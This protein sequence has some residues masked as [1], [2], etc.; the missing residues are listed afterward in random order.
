MYTMYVCTHACLHLCMC[1]CV[2]ARLHE[3]PG[4]MSIP[5]TST[6]RQHV[7][8]DLSIHLSLCIQ[9]MNLATILPICLAISDCLSP[10]LT[11]HLLIYLSMYLPGCKYLISTHADAHVCT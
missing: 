3:H 1:A 7:D 9:L 4:R 8:K 10:L 5:V 2:R 6:P 11:M